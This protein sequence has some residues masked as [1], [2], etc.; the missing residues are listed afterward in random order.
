MYLEIQNIKRP[1]IDFLVTEI[2]LVEIIYLCITWGKTLFVYDGKALTFSDL[3]E[4]L[5]FFFV[6]IHM[7]IHIFINF[8]RIKKRKTPSA[9]ICF[10]KRTST[11]RDMVCALIRMV[12]ETKR[13]TGSNTWK[14]SSSLVDVCVCVCADVRELFSLSLPCPF[15]SC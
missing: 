2:D 7:K 9:K 4:L 11:Q 3:N 8:T 5:F 6:H 1:N 15:F 12:T 14:Y 10:N 13:K